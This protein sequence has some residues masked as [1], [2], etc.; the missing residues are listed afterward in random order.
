MWRQSAHP[1]PVPGS[2][3][4]IWLGVVSKAY[5][6]TDTP[7]E[8]WAAQLIQRADRPC[9]YMYA[10]RALETYKSENYFKTILHELVV[11]DL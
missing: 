9:H 4:N 8:A 5:V 10:G 11:K 2:S 6:T 7:V 1:H 3:A